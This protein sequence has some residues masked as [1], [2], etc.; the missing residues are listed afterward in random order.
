MQEKRHHFRKP[1]NYSVT[2]STS[3]GRRCQGTCRDFSLGG[4]AIDTEFRAQFGA[5]VIVYMRLRGLPGETALEGIVRWTKG[6]TMGVQFGLMGA[7]QTYALTEMLATDVECGDESPT[8][9]PRG[10]R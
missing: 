6:A 2:F 7:H 5:K 8:S 1:T 10:H 4:I 9:T 3:D